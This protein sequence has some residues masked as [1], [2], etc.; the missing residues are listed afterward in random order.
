MKFLFVISAGL[1]TD[2]TTD[3]MDD[4]NS[5]KEYSIIQCRHCK[6]EKK[7]TFVGYYPNKKDKRWIDA[8]TGR[9]F[10][11]RLCPPCDVEKKMRTQRLKRRVKRVRNEAAYDKAG[12]TDE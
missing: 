12:S 3:C 6:E 5:T 8:E 9:E 2:L 1:G 4:D 7:R 10:N 11:G